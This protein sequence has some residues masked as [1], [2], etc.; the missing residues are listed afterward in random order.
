MTYSNL[1]AFGHLLKQLAADNCPDDEMW[2]RVERMRENHEIEM[3]GNIPLPSASWRAELQEDGHYR[4]KAPGRDF[5]ANNILYR[6][7]VSEPPV[8]IIL[9]AGLAMMASKIEAAPPE[10][11]QSP[12]KKRKTKAEHAA[13]R[14][15]AAD[16]E[17]RALI[18]AVDAYMKVHSGCSE[19]EALESM[20]LNHIDI[21]SKRKKL[22][23][24]RERVGT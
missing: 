9:S 4:I 3:V 6:A 22:R 16:A 17:A 1:F 7:R 18:A 10:V 12:K 23:R 2:E 13:A 11:T 21:G 8:R 15:S 14:K 5:P 19:T 24:A 20:P